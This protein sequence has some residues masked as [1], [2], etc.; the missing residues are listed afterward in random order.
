MNLY[1]VNCHPTCWCFKNILFYLYGCCD[2]CNGSIWFCNEDPHMKHLGVAETW[3][4][5]G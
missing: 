1:V 2:W 3:Y 4:G 5:S